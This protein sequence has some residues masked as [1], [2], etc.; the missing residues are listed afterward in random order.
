M[1]LLINTYL[2]YSSIETAANLQH[3]EQAN[4]YLYIWRKRL[5][6]NRPRLL[7]SSH[8]SPPSTRYYYLFRPVYLRKRITIHRR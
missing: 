7:S 5:V 3:I 6:V 8:V 1:F 4:N 2:Y